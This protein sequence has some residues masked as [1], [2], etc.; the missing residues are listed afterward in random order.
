M[1][2]PRS[3]WPT[4]IAV[5]ALAIACSS[6]DQTLG[7]TRRAPSPAPDPSLNPVPVPDPTPSPRPEPSNPACEDAQKHARVGICVNVGTCFGRP[8]TLAGYDCPAGQT[9]CE[10]P[11]GCSQSGCGGSGTGSV[12]GASGDTSAGASG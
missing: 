6:R 4:L 1:K 9:C 3:A 5:A 2:P 8:I 11:V 7:E 12:I 10:N